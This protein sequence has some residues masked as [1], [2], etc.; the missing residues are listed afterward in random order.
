MAKIY[1]TEQDREKERVIAEIFCKHMGFDYGFPPVRA[2]YDFHIQ[3]NG[4]YKGKVINTVLGMAEVKVRT[5]SIDTYPTFM[6][7][8]EKMIYM[9]QFGSEHITPY[10][11]VCWTDAIGWIDFRE[12]CFLSTGGRYD[13]D[14]P[15]DDKLV[16]H[17]PIDRFNL[18]VDKR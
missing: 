4:T 13:R 17:Y 12:K 11:V 15:N 3:R 10:L 7:D 16:V 2:R 14:D 9:R 8:A 18:L 5:C 6:I 1:E